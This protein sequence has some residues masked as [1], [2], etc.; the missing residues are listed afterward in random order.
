MLDVMASGSMAVLPYLICALQTL[1]PGPVTM[2]MLDVMASGSTAVLPY[3]ICASQIL[4]PGHIAIRTTTKCWQ[5]RRRRKK[6]YLQVCLEQ[7]KNF[8]PMVYSVNG[9]AGRDA[10]H[11]E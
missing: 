2:E 9:I 3:S 11:A 4:K 10:R 8:T 5:H 7:R 6:K 1:K